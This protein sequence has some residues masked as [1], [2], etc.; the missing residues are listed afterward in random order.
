MFG[1][2]AGYHRYFSHRSY[3]TSRLFQF[4]LA[5]LGTTAAQKGV[6]WWAA[7]HRYHHRHSDK[8]TDVHSPKQH[9]FLWAHIGWFLSRDYQRTDLNS[10]RDFARFPELRWL[11]RWHIVPPALLAGATYLVGGV[12]GLVWGFAL[13]T[14]C[15]WHAT[16]L[17]NSIAHLVGT[18]RFDTED[19]SRNSLA[20]S[21]LTL[22]EG[23]HNNHHRYPTSSRHG[24]ASWELDVTY[25]GL[26]MLRGIGV[27][28]DLRK[29]PEHALTTSKQPV[30]P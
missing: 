1:I 21:L 2:T 22:G 17:I 5:L 13:S 19:D 25:L 27:I 6:L 15:C 29:P 20:L 9:G 10:I 12:P 28:W 23:W 24:L 26:V 7:H 3:R 30:S 11:N 18:R 16:Y 14:V 4:V 8:P